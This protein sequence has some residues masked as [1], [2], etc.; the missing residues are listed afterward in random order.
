MNDRCPETNFQTGPHDWRLWRR[1]PKYEHTKKGYT[2]FSGFGEVWYCTR[3][4]KI[5]E[6]TVES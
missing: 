4:R 2:A 6:R 5:E 1:E 3:C